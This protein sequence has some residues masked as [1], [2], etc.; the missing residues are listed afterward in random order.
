MTPSLD[1]PSPSVQTPIYMRGLNHRNR[2]S[3]VVLMYF[4]DFS[5][6]LHCSKASTLNIFV[7]TVDRDKGKHIDKGKRSDKQENT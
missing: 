2:L 7:Q 1:I 4:Y 6:I 5:F 3:Q